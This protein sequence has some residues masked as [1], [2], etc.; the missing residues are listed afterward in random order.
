VVDERDLH[1][2]RFPPFIGRWLAGYLAR[3]RHVHSTAVPTARALLQ[4]CLRPGDVLLVEG[5]SRVSTAVKYLTQ[6]TWSHA[7]L[8]VGPRPDLGTGNNNGDGEA[9]CFVE[10]DMV[11]GVRAVGLSQFVGLHARICRPASLS[12]HDIERVIA[13]V[14]ARLGHRYDLR[15]VVDLVRYLLPTPPVPLRWRRRLLV[16]GSGDPTRAICSTLIAQA[17]EAV[18][19]PILPSVEQRSTDD[20]LCPDCVDE[21]LHVRHHSLFVPRDFDVSPYFAVVKPTLFADFD[22]RRLLWHDAAA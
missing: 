8:Y 5:N 10:A 21:I 9:P 20:P 17:F 16:L 2:M 1:V 18:R 15:N 4:N 19:Y 14:V 22:H 12:A 7:A 6:S 3:P 11:D 13:H